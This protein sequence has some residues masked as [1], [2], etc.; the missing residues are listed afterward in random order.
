MTQTGKYKLAGLCS[1]T[2][3]SSSS[4]NISTIKRPLNTYFDQVFTQKRY[5]IA[6]PPVQR[7]MFGKKLR[8]LKGW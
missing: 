3:A 4:K 1:I 5:K 8:A 2:E 6:H 7:D